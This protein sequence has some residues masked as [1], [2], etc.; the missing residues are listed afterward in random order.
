MTKFQPTIRVLNQHLSIPQLQPLI[1]RVSIGN[2]QRTW[3][4]EDYILLPST[5]AVKSLS[6]AEIDGL[7]AA[8]VRFD[9]FPFAWVVDSIADEVPV[10]I[11][12]EFNDAEEGE[13]PTRRTWAEWSM[14][15][16]PETKDGKFLIY[17]DGCF[18]SRQMAHEELAPVRSGYTVILAYEGTSLLPEPEGL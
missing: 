11:P 12:G 14:S 1:N 16:T 3:D 4:G 10:G 15:G 17:S 9:Y 8:G 2:M 5:Q 13:A 6:T 18:S 7:I